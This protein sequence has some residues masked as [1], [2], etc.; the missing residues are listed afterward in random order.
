M[1]PTIMATQLVS[2]CIFYNIAF[3]VHV[4]DKVYN[5]ACIYT[6]SVKNN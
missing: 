5:K 3:S 1:I 2:E 6:T 4:Y